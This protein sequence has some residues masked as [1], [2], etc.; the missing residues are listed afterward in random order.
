MKSLVNSIFCIDFLFCFFQNF[1][2]KTSF[3]N[4]YSFLQSKLIL[5]ARAKA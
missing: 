3:F 2:E 1:S 5:K 4:K